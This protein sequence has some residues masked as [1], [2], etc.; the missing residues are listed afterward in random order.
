VEVEEVEKVRFLWKRFDWKKLKMKA[1]PKN[2]TSKKLIA[3]AVKHLTDPTSLIPID[4][5]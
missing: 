5:V 2:K 3:E 1:I 4:Y